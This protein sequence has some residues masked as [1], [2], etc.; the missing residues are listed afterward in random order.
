MNILLICGNGVSSGMIAQRI[1]KAGIKR[2]YPDTK[3]EA[4]SYSQLEEVA[5]SFDVVLAAPQLK[6]FEASIK[7]TC[8]RHN[9]PYGIIDNMTYSMLDGDKGF[10]MV[11]KLLNEKEK[12]D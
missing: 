7:E 10:D 6:F 3:A 11:L 9:R 12:E 8:E 5:D 2:G 1:A 4:Y